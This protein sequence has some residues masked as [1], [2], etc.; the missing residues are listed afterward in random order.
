MR[1][2]WE[3]NVFGVLMV[4]QA[5]LPLLRESSA[6]RI[7]V[8]VADNGA[9]AMGLALTPQVGAHIGRNWLVI[10]GESYARIAGQSGYTAT[11]NVLLEYG[12]DHDEDNPDGS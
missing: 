6:A 10:V 9:T 11:T 3:T 4:Y 12:F 2:V 7:V 8:S 1:A 5:M